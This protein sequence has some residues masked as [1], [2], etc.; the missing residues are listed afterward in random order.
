MD[1]SDW[2]YQEQRPKVTQRAWMKKK[3]MERVTV[4]TISRVID[5]CIASLHYGLDLETTGLNNMTYEPDFYK[6]RT[7]DQIVGVCLAPSVDV[8]YYIPLRHQKGEEHNVPF[9]FFHKEMKRLVES[10]AKA[11]FHKGKFDQEFLQYNGGEPL[12]LW[13]DP[14]SWEDTLIL[15]SLIDTSQK[16][17]GLKGLSKKYLGHEMI[18]LS[19]LYDEN[20]KDKDFSKLDP[21][22]DPVIWYAASDAI[23]TLELFH[24]LSPTILKGDEKQENQRQVYALEKMLVPAVRWM[25]R[26]GIHVD[27][28]KVKELICLGQKEYYDCLVDVYDFCEKALGRDVAPGWFQV[29]KQDKNL[30][31]SDHHIQEQIEEAKLKAKRQILDTLD[32]KGK[33]AKVTVEKDGISQEWPSKYDILSRPQLGPLFEELEI[34]G[35]RRTD[36]SGQ[37]KTTQDEID[38]LEGIH[39]DKY[40]FLPKIKRMG[41]LQKA[42]GTYLISLLNDVGPDKCIH[43]NFNQHGTDTGRFTTPSSKKP[44]GRCKFPVHGTPA[45]YDKSRPQ[46][47]LRIREAISVRSPE[48][49][50]LCI[51]YSGVELRIAT[52][53]SQEPLWIAE[54]FRCSNCGHEFDRGDGE[55]TPEAPP[56]YCPSCGS[57]KIGDL[58]SKT[59]V[60]FYGS[61]KVGTK[62][63]K[64]LRQQAK[65]ANFS[66]AY[67]GGPGALMRSTGCDE[68]EA[69][70]HHKA[71]NATYKGLS[72]WW[73]YVKGFCRTKGY[74]RTDFGRQYHL[75][76]IKLPTSARDEPDPEK[77]RMNHKFRAK[78][79][80]NA[81]NGPVQGN[82]ADI[83]KLAMALI[84]KEVKKRGWFDKV[85]MTITIHDEL[86]FEVHKSIV[87]EA[88]ELFQEIMTRN[89]AILKMKWPIPLT[90]DCEIGSNWTAPY[91]IKDFKYGFVRQDGMQID[92]ETHEET[93]K[94]WPQ[95]YL[96]LFGPVYGF[97]KGEASKHD[98]VIDTE[99]SEAIEEKTEDLSPS[100][101]SNPTVSPEPEKRHEAGSPFE[102]RLKSWDMGTVEKLAKVI[103]KTAG[104][105]TSPLI[106]LSPSGEPGLWPDADIRVSPLEFEALAGVHGL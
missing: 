43:A 23:C 27:R 101:Q 10:E 104:R 28:E 14:M 30:D 73:E 96:D 11:V 78:A 93:G 13:D 95:E 38:R 5:E 16:S 24:V 20:A 35:I 33:Y 61:S 54:Y 21:S 32:E 4:E 100:D 80:R 77:R 36:K 26:G 1:F 94:V 59:A 57:D 88:I 91:D 12:G 63:F 45:T 47:L 51:D 97:Y 74:V 76:D 29:L 37:V 82:S 49:L 90:T 50:M 15:G 67:G 58:H 64:Q 18:E 103:L 65:S 22:W 83:T 71:F 79:E 41:E 17:A 84:Y 87:A 48:F 9:S 34:P 42:L 98:A 99:G 52:N 85:F 46:C 3:R 81:T 53:Y 70:R 39:G 55:S 69:A 89:K 102:F 105:G 72:S 8:G 31:D 56:S 19:D 44:D 75:P 2:S 6:G 86:V 60:T 25:E 106:V 7:Q 92:P 66:L 62:A 68:N 40:P